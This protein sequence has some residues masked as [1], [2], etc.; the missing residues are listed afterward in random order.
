M[1]LPSPLFLLLHCLPDALELCFPHLLRFITFWIHFSNM[2]DKGLLLTVKLNTQ[3]R[4]EV[5]I[6]Y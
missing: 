5:P 6:I 3:E 4:T 1:L 2:Y